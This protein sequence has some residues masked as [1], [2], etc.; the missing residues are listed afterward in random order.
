MVV[1][2]IGEVDVEEKRN[3]WAWGDWR[4]KSVNC[5]TNTL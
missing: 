2:S 3:I 4:E 5:S 1:A